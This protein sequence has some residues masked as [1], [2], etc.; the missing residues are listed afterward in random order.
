[1]DKRKILHEATKWFLATFQDLTTYET[2]YGYAEWTLY[3][4]P[5]IKTEEHFLFAAKLIILVIIGDDSFREHEYVVLM[6]YL[7]TSVVNDSSPFISAIIKLFDDFKAVSIYEENYHNMIKVI[8][9]FFDSTVGKK[10]NDEM[11]R[12]IDTGM[13]PFYIISLDSNHILAD[14]NNKKMLDSSYGIRIDNDLL[15]YPK[16][17][18]SDYMLD[19]TN[20]VYAGVSIGDQ[21]NAIEDHCTTQLSRV[22]PTL[23]DAIYLQGRM[24]CFIWQLFTKRYGRILKTVQA[25]Q[26]VPPHIPTNIIKS[27]VG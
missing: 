16:D 25:H 12:I 20:P 6:D 14:M 17:T 4:V 8:V 22:E 27:I 13:P 23:E 9:A 5:F 24:G 19:H 15:S 26:C 10:S 18:M 2:A 21:V 7:K 1:M 3:A 11:D